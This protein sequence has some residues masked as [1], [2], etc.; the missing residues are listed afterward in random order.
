MTDTSR[1]MGR[2]AERS[3]VETFES[4]GHRCVKSTRHEN[5]RE[6]WDFL[7]DDKYKVEVKAR[8][9]ERRDDKSPNDEWI[10]VEFKNIIGY[11]GWLYGRADYIAFERPNG[12]LVVPRV[13]LVKAAEDKIKLV[14]TDRPTPYKS[15]RRWN[16][17]DEH[18]GV[19][20]INDILQLPN[21]LVVKK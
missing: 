21:R 6:H 15:Y 7:V 16:R 20:L 10:Y 8:K 1:Q 19:L 17:S 12:F 5:M 14:W 18:V 4:Q 2:D 3:F 13:L 11:P 9:K